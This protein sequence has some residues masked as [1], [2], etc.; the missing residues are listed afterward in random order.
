MGGV[1][2]CVDLARCLILIYLKVRHN[3]EL[4]NF[5]K[6]AGWNQPCNLPGGFHGLRVML[7]VCVKPT[8][9]LTCTLAKST[10]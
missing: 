6:F 2:W 9:T 4:Q 5:A 7:M 8:V 3:P 1:V 10:S